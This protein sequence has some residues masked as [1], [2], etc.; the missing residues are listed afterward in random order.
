PLLRPR[1]V[2][3]LPHPQRRARPSAPGRGAEAAGAAGRA[4]QSLFLPPGYVLLLAGAG[5]GGLVPRGGRRLR[6]PGDRDAR[7]AAGGGRGFTA[8]SPQRLDLW[9]GPRPA[10]VEP[11]HRGRAEDG[12]DVE[13]HGQAEPDRAVE[14]P[15][16]IAAPD[17]PLPL[18]G[19]L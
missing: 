11:E 17:V 7:A 4:G 12:E 15:V 18:L 2:R 19:R 3:R 8:P 16:E 1:A 13:E 5:S 6:P 9:R 10:A 14:R